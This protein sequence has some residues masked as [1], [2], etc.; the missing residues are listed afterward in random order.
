MSNTF[1]L[2][3]PNKRPSISIQDSQNSFA[4][5]PFLPC[6]SRL[7]LC[8]S[9]LSTPSLLYYSPAP[10][11]LHKQRLEDILIQICEEQNNSTAFAESSMISFGNEASQCKCEKAKETPKEISAQQLT[12]PPKPNEG[13][14]AD[15]HEKV[16][17]FKSE[18]RSEIIR[19]GLKDITNIPHKQENAHIETA[20]EKIIRRRKRKTSE[21]LRLLEIEY[22][23][24]PDWSKVKMSEVAYRTGLSEAQ[25]YKWGWDQKKKKTEEEI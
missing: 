2:T 12:T 7:N 1:Q 23:R 9:P 10:S 13:T 4:L 16:S 8:A 25:V 24:N 5:S 19:S 18:N 20:E 11:E 22:E 21:Q 15:S 6:S 17:E 3:T 14:C